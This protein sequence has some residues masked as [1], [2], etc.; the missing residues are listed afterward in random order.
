M[1]WHNDLLYN[2]NVD[3]MLI[4]LH[5]I[6]S[7]IIKTLHVQ[8]YNHPVWR[9]KC[10]LTFWS[11]SQGPRASRTVSRKVSPR[12]SRLWDG[13]A[14]SCGC[15]RGTNPR[16]PS[17]SPTPASCWSTRT[18]CSPSEPAGRYSLTTNPSPVDLLLHDAPRQ[19][20]T[21]KHESIRDYKIQF[22]VFWVKSKWWE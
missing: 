21:G 11:L 3:W 6:I 13:L 17:T 19:Y 8:E 22:I 9:L 5:S 1:R 18:W 16:R 2:G 12:P 14:C 7:A 15:W 10:N 20:N 4:V